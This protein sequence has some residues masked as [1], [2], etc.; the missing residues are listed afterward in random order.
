MGNSGLYTHQ[1]PG[2]PFC[3]KSISLERYDQR[4]HYQNKGS[5]KAIQDDTYLSHRDS[6]FR[7]KLTSLE[8][9]NGL[10]RSQQ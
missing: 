5:H 8:P 2:N 9:D 7:V 10:E 4:S 1:P 3:V 6:P